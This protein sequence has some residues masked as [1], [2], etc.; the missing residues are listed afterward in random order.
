MTKE[1]MYEAY[2]QLDR[3]EYTDNLT[4]FQI[5]LLKEIKYFQE[6]YGNFKFLKQHYITKY[7]EILSEKEILSEID[8]LIDKGFLVKELKKTI[9]NAKYSTQ[10][11]LIITI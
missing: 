2:D 9:F 10:I 5:A 1:Q 8:E 3:L 6:T 11:I 4:L 7:G